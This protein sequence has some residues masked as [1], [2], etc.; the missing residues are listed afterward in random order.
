MAREL[1]IRH[2]VELL[3]DEEVGLLAEKIRKVLAGADVITMPTKEEAERK[4]DEH[5]S[6]CDDEGFG[7]ENE[8]DAKAAWMN[9]YYYIVSKLVK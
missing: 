9:C 3:T 5:L 6:E 7:Y 8:T 1:I 2:D 4:C